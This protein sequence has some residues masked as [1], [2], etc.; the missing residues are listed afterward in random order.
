MHTM[1]S[2]LRRL[3]VALF[4][5]ALTMSLSAVAS[6]LVP[7]SPFPD[8]RIFRGRIHSRG[9]EPFN[10]ALQNKIIYLEDATQLLTTW[11]LPQ[12]IRLSTVS[13]RKNQC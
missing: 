11:T 8:Q 12:T 9:S 5:A 2:I 13:L 1:R 6:E 10:I 3:H 4:A 7:V